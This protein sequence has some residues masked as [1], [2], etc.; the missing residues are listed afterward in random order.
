MISLTGEIRIR[1]RYFK[2]VTACKFQARSFALSCPSSRLKMETLLRDQSVASSAVQ[3]PSVAT[4]TPAR[5]TVGTEDS[6]MT[7][8]DGAS[9][10][11]RKHLIVAFDYGTTFSSV[12]YTLLDRKGQEP[13]LNQIKTINRYPGDTTPNPIDE[14]PT[15]IWYRDPEAPHDDVWDDS[16]FSSD[17]HSDDDDDDDDD[18]DP[19]PDSRHTHASA[20]Q[21]HKGNLP[22]GYTVRE[23]L[24]F[25][26]SPAYTGRNIPI[27]RGKLLLDRSACTKALRK[28]LRKTLSGLKKNKIIEKDEDVIADFLTCLFHFTKQQL[29]QKFYLID[30]P[31]IE[32]VLCVPAL[33]TPRA[34]RKMH[35]ATAIA[36]DRTGLGQTKN[37]CVENLF[38]VS[39]PEAAAAYVLH[40]NYEIQVQAS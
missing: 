5:A 21:V 27:T 10:I 7:G 30:N 25:P 11:H 12:A 17:V 34:R 29:E 15:E 28:H 36:V 22:W 3:P 33:W 35:Q 24:R 39:E 38:I 31:T 14:V 8:I 13:S 1:K 6:Y 20:R 16:D 2:A 9:Q 37:N 40:G 19:H 26:D 4:A 23:G 18:D 32:L